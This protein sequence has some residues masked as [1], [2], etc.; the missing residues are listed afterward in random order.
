MREAGAGAFVSKDAAAEQL[1]DV[2]TALIP[3]HQDRHA[4]GS[5]Q[6]ELPFS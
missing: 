2:I 3:W 6:A 5:I 1:H 4:S